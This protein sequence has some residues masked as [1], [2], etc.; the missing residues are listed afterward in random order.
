MRCNTRP[1][2]LLMMPAAYAAHV[3]AQLRPINDTGQRQYFTATAV[4]PQPDPVAFPGQDPHY[5]RDAAA[6][7]D[8]LPKL[9]R[10]AAG[11]DFTKLSATGQPL[12]IQDQ[13]WARDAAGLDAGSE[14]A[15]TRWTCVRDHTTGLDW[16]VRTRTATPGLR[17]M[18]RGY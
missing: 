7:D 3:G 4:A 16:E 11:F 18:R 14:A 15:G 5:G 1:L 13:A 6:A 10:G 17:E 12:A 2:L 9:G 8:A